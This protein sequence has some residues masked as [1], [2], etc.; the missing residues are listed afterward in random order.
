MK[1][2]RN[3]ILSICCFCLL[4]VN[5]ASG[6]SLILG[7]FEASEDIAH[8][9]VIQK[10][11]H[12]TGKVHFVNADIN[13][14]DEVAFNLF[15]FDAMQT[16]ASSIEPVLAISTLAYLQEFKQAPKAQGF[17]EPAFKPPRFSV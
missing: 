2:I 12:Q 8:I 4:F 11:D 1:S 7:S 15:Y 17:I 6:A 16:P 5:L 3:R 10:I 9:E 13:T 14:E